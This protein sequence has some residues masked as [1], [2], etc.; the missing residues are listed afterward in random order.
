MTMTRKHFNALA[1]SI[2]P[3][4]EG[5]VKMEGADHVY[6]HGIRDT[7]DNIAYM[8]SKENSNFDFAKFKD[9]CGYYLEPKQENERDD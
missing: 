8:C 2:R 3:L 4:M 9:A 5:A 1:K 7:I 6:I